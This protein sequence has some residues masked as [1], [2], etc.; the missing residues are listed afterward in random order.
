MRSK[1]ST[2]KWMRTSRLKMVFC[3]YYSRVSCVYMRR[4]ML[5]PLLMHKI[6][7]SVVYFHFV[8]RWMLFGWWIWKT[9]WTVNWSSNNNNRKQKT[10]TTTHSELCINRAIKTSNI[11]YTKTEIVS[12]HFKT[13][14]VLNWI[15]K[16]WKKKRKVNKSQSE[17][18]SKRKRAKKNNK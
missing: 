6:Y 4:R 10:H 1:L 5:A 17:S 3:I 7:I 13:H 9:E 8:S 15:G 14:C 18:Q 12:K 2:N 16:R 11:G